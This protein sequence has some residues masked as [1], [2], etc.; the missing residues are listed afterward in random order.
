MH[1]RVT[2]QPFEARPDLHDL[3]HLGIVL[4]RL[5][6]LGRIPL[7]A[8]ERRLEIRE[9][10][11]QASLDEIAPLDPRAKI[12]KP[13]ELIDRRYLVELEKSGIFDK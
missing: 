7:R 11:L 1:A 3:R 8:L 10:A 9:A 13:Q 6:E 5:D 2:R 4:H 12:I